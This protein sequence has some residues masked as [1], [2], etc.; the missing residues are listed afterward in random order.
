MSMRSPLL[1]ASA[2]ACASLV[3]AH[4]AA[5]SEDER[6]VVHVLNRITFGARPEEVARVSQLGLTRYIEEQLHPE[7][8]DDR[9]FSTRLAGFQ[10]LELSA[11]ELSRRYELPLLEARREQKQGAAAAGS[12]PSP[13]AAPRQE[14][15]MAAEREAANLPLVELS[16]QKLLRAAYSERQLQEVLT[17]FWFNHF[18]VDA[19]KGPE[20]FLLTEYERDVIRPHVLGRF[21]DLLGAT[22]KSPAM[23]FYL[24]NWLS[25]DPNGPHPSRAAQPRFGGVRRRPFGPD[26]FPR[27]PMPQTQQPA[28]QKKG[29]NENYGR[30]LMELH[31][32]GV[33]GGYTQKDVTE[34]ARAFTGWT[35]D[36]PRLGGGFRFD[37]RLHDDGEKVILGHRIKAGGG[38]HD[39]E[40]VLDLLASQP[41]TAKFIASK[42]VRRFVNDLPP[43]QL[44]DRA[45]AKFR[46]SGGDLRAVMTVILTSPEFLAP[47]NYGAKVKTPFE[48]VVSALRATGA[49]VDDA[50]VLVR[51]VQQL[52]MPLYQ[53]QPPTGYKDTSDAWVNAGALVNRMNFGLALAARRLPGVTLRDDPRP[54][55]VVAGD[56][57][58]T[59]RATIAKAET[60]PQALALALG[61]PEF[62]RR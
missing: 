13:D 27:R 55:T 8:I 35:I 31:T 41:S 53:C 24:D 29:L 37:A 44:V 5:R 32:L 58:D 9:G 33:D 54:D 34:V 1:L 50:R 60:A 19:R 18:N 23:L 21:R 26:P 12:T 59:T 61:S 49:D 56:L 25:A 48:F 22:A 40:E 36:T 11:R 14:P 10:T 3:V 43:Q 4:G 39:G 62:Q 6:A 45:A 2:L 7:R 52:G 38:M 42:L 20:R 30:E 46:D 16:E 17:D 51:Q 28:A 15:R 47:A 57:S